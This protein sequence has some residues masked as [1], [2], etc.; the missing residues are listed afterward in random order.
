MNQYKNYFENTKGTGILATVDGDGSPNMAVYARPHAQEDGTLAV[1]M[2]HNKSYQNIQ[3]NPH[4]SYLYLEDGPGYRGKR[5]HLTRIRE[6]DNPELIQ[7][8]KR[9]NYS[10]ERE[11]AM[12]PLHLVFFEVRKERPL[13]G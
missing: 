12:K 4:A 9:R 6:E 13:V 5:L 11:E 3:S 2:A 8:L 1:I 7:S 10:K